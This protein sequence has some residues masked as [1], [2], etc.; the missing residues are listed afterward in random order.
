MKVSIVSLDFAGVI[1]PKNFIDYFWLELIPYAYSLKHCVEL[2][3][4]KRIVYEEY[5]RVGVDK[6]EWYLIEYWAKRFSIEEYTP[7]LLDMA[8]TKISIYPD[9]LNVLPKLHD[10]VNKIIIVTNT[11]IPFI[12]LFFKA[13]PEVEK[14]INRIYSCVTHYNLPRKTKEFYIKVVEDLHVKPYEIVHV[15]DDPLYDFKIP[16][17]IGI[18]AFILIRDKGKYRNVCEYEQY[19]IKSLND[20][21]EIV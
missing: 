20:L 6:V 8:Y 17:S 4:A 12:N 5:S 13:Y 9:V 11:T 16:R 7:Q 21:L 2:S 15:G 19:I 3:K 1:T 18:Y 10:R 14:Y